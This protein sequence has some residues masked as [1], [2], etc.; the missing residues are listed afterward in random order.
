MTGPGRLAQDEVIEEPSVTISGMEEKESNAEHVEDLD[1]PAPKVERI[2]EAA[3]GGGKAKKK[4]DK[5]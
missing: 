1:I 5:K 4:K 3:G 2:S